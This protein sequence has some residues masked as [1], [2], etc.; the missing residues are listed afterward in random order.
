MFNQ[1]KVEK[2]SIEN[3]QLKNEVE[4][5]KLKLENQEREISKFMVELQEELVTTIEQHGTVNDQHGILA[6]L[7]RKIKDHFETASELV[8]GSS[9]C[10]KNLNGTGEGL[11]QSAQVLEKK[12]EE[13][14]SIVKELEALIRDLGEEINANMDS[15]MRVGY[16]SKEID[17]IVVLIKGIA[18]Q[19]NLLALNA[20]IEAARAGEYG[21]GFAV[22]A[23]EVRK[24]AEETATSSHNI[25]KLMKSFQGD[26]DQ[27]VNNTKECFGLVQTG[28]D[29]SM[30]TTEKIGDVREIIQNVANQV[31]V[32]QEIIQEQN[33]FCLNTLSEMNLTN[34]IFEAINKLILK[35]IDDASVVDEKL[36][37]GVNQLKENVPIHQ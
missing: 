18:E 19:T 28:R 36:E 5:L 3:T 4:S 23:E 15:I 14:Q 31:N 1:K 8:Q 16:Q 30:K 26:I 11:L 12:G 6:D 33:A 34:E 13:G 21:K 25:M 29:L 35:H 22:V 2:L 27:A 10:A 9:D 24:L 17:D 32:A 37:N 20:S 7:V